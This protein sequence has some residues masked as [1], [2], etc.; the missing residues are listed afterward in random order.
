MSFQN[1]KLAG[2]N[3]DP[4]F[5]HDVPFERGSVEYPVSPSML[6]QFAHC[7]SR[8]LRG[9]NPPETKGKD[10]GSVI[11]CL[12]LTPEQFSHKYAIQPLTYE[13]EGMQ[14]PV[15]KTISD[16]KSCREHKVDRVRVIVNKEWSGNS[17]ICQE[18][19][20]IQTENG[21]EVIT[22]D[23][24]ADATL[25]ITR[26]KSDDVLGPYMEQSRRQVLVTGEWHDEPTGLTIPVRCL[27][28]LAP[29]DDSEFAGSLGD[30]K[31]TRTAALMAFQRDVFKYGY[32]LQAAFDLA[33]FN[34]ATGQERTDWCFLVQESYHPWQTGRR[35]L[36]QDFIDLGRCDYKRLLGNYCACVKSGKWPDYDEND[37]AVQGWSI[38]SPAPW[39][40]TQCQFSPKYE[41]DEPA[42]QTSQP[43]TEENF[44]ICP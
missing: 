26:L 29:A 39:M 20:E 6:K 31:T 41:F 1:C 3:V 44:D 25:A 16:S 34:A 9:Y 7:P 5:Y 35:L 18:W 22:A 15:C 43:E 28:D 42:G 33:L 40:A 10:F 4:Q 24:L 19:S 11:D 27:I 12:L 38:V 14:C 36:A 21:K 23:I 37:E 13:S 8:W 17:K 2:E 32:H 30:V